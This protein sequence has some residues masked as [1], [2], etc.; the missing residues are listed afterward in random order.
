MS[1]LI[2]PKALFTDREI[3]AMRDIPE[4][5]EALADWHECQATMG[6]AMDIN[7]SGN[8]RRAEE[9]RRIAQEIIENY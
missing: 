2:E 5:L 1:S 3:E 4:V 8:E 9:L 6:D 7:C